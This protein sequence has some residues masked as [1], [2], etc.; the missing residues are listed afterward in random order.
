MN[1]IYFVDSAKLFPKN[2]KSAA[3]AADLQQE[4]RRGKNEKDRLNRLITVYP[5]VVKKKSEKL[6]RKNEVL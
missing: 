3:Q 2:A 1:A 6:L 5:K 4:K